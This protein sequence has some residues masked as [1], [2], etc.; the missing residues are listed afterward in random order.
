MPNGAKDRFISQAS[1]FRW[2]MQK[3]NARRLPHS[4]KMQSGA[5]GQKLAFY[6]L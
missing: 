2:E 3:A 5:A 4:R 6:D 1:K